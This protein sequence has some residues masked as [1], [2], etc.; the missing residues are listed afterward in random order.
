MPEQKTPAKLP[1]TMFIN[2]EKTPSAAG[3]TFPI[4][5]PATGEELSHLPDAS[6]P[7]IDHAV[8]TSKAAFE[9]DTWRRMPPATR[10]RLLLKLA[11]LVEQHTDEL[12]TLET[13]NQGKLIA[14][15]KML[16]VSGSVQ[17]LR[18][19]AGWATKIE[20]T[21]FRPVDPLPTGHPL[22]R[23]NKTRPSRRGRR[24]RPVEF[25]APDGGLENRP[26]PRMRLHRRAETSG[27]NAA[28]SDPTGRTGPRSR[29]PARRIQRR[30][31][32]RRNRW[33]SAGQAS[34][35][36]QGHLHGID[37]SRP[38]HRPPMR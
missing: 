30:H 20:G 14:F 3:K 17:W 12:A 19:M 37:R 34:A 24:N 9:S 27:R 5:N 25:P 16:E 23:L 10:E 22:Q 6:E 29:L 11:D 32:P 28:D 4:Y 35:R 1:T 33:R 7:D 21:H 36:E 2:G 18:Y 8:K 38:H 15:S 26:G 31:R 13:L